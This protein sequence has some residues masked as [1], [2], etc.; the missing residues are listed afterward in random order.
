[1][2]TVLPL[3]KSAEGLK[4]KKERKKEEN[5]LYVHFLIM[6][7]HMLHWQCFRCLN[8]AQPGLR[9]EIL[10]IQF[11]NIFPGCQSHFATKKNPPK[12]KKN[13]PKNSTRNTNYFSQERELHLATCST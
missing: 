10:I 11:A 9:H 1:L 7:L 13:P 3:K 2:K 6:H 5:A 4:R 12:N 8:L